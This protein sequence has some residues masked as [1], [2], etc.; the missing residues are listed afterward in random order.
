MGRGWR[1]SVVCWC[2]CCLGGR[3]GGGE[4]ELAMFSL[5]EGCWR[6][7]LEYEVGR[8]STRGFFFFFLEDIDCCSRGCGDG[9]GVSFACSVSLGVGERERLREDVQAFLV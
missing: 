2:W 4:L 6:R 8:G 5:L 9:V 3:G 7:S 1:G